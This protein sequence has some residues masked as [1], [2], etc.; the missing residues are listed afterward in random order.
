MS[1][2]AF[3]NPYPDY[4]VLAKWRSPSW[5]EQTRDV[6][7]QR[8][9]DVPPRRFLTETQFA[10]LDAVCDRVMPQPERDDDKVPIAPFIDARLHA[11]RTS[12]TRYEPLPT[13][14]EC[15]RR[16][17]DA[18]EAEAQHHFRRAY[19]ALDPAEQDL[20]LHAMNKGE[21]EAPAW[22]PHLPAK[23][24]MR[25]ELLQVIVETYYAHPAAWSEVGFGGPASPRGYVRLQPN[26]HDSWE[27]EERDA[28]QVRAAAYK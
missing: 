5:N 14:R 13:M 16:G 25:H 20:I 11:N 19:V 23:K 8:L 28:S 17:L 15:W 12:G 21:T 6:V 2:R 26:R 10:T 27:G 24:F 1:D 22:G 3:R 18:I 7:A 4:D 9:H